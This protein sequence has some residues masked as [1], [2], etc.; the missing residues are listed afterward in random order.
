MLVVYYFCQLCFASLCFALHLPHG[1][2]SFLH[3]CRLFS[4]T[5]RRQNQFS[6]HRIATMDQA[7][8]IFRKHVQP[9]L[10][11]LNAYLNTRDHP[12]AVVQAFAWA[13]QKTHIS[14][15]HL[16]YGV[17][18]LFLLLATIKNGLLLLSLLVGTVYP[19]Y[20]SFKAIES[21]EKDD[22]TQ[23][24]VYWVVFA[25]FSLAEPFVDALMWWL[26]VYYLLKLT[27]LIA[28]MYPDRKHNLSY[29]LYYRFI[30]RF[31]VHHQRLATGKTDVTEPPP[32]VPEKK[33]E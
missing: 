6:F 11:R 19:G 5:S 4:S 21:K 24:L 8:R 25:V 16:F 30:R 3:A 32:A 33:T 14:R 10:D 1:Q 17:V 12:D 29:V 23:W 7:K 22:D 26:P 2:S 28:C 31:L 15:L 13:E 18:G 9:L 27:V 20:M